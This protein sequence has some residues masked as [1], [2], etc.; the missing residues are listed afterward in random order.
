LNPAMV[1]LFRDMR[2]EMPRR[3]GKG[4][5]FAD[6]TVKGIS[7]LTCS[8]TTPLVRRGCL[9][10]T[11]AVYSYP[12]IHTVRSFTQYNLSSILNSLRTACTHS[13]SYEPGC[14][15]LFSPAAVTS[16]SHE[17]HVAIPRPPQR[18]L[19]GSLPGS[20]QTHTTTA[21]DMATESDPAVTRVTVILNTPD[22]WFT[23]LF[24]RRDAANRHGL[25][26]YIKPDVARELLPELAVLELG[27]L[28]VRCKVRLE[29]L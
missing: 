22:D 23:W 16:L 6:V 12:C 28:G 20:I 9:S 18:K 3:N 14:T 5:R 11:S 2:A 19:P 17:S 8:G 26:Q 25:W 7:C 29:C 21:S 13:D 24:I 15:G 1:Y 4:A 10:C 27:G